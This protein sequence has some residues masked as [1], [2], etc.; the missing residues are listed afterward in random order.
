M[1]INYIYWLMFS[2]CHTRGISLWLYWNYL[3]ASSVTA[4]IE[5][6]FFNSFEIK[7]AQN[8][9]NWYYCRYFQNFNRLPIKRNIYVSLK[10]REKIILKSSK[11]RNNKKSPSKNKITQRLLFFLSFGILSIVAD[12]SFLWS[13]KSN[14]SALSEN[15][16]RNELQKNVK[17]KRRVRQQ[18]VL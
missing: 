5:E 6:I 7:R 14:I 15:F 4:R 11:Y 1:H 16:R 12:S 18:T 13:I 2:L 17:N 9:N 10:L 3:L 8:M